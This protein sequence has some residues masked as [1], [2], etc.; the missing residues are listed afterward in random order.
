MLW[1]RCRRRLRVV[2]II[3][4]MSANDLPGVSLLGF[5]AKLLRRG[6]ATFAERAFLCVF[7]SVQIT[8]ASLQGCL[9]STRVIFLQELPKIQETLRNLRTMGSMG[10]YT[11]V[12]GAL[13]AFPVQLYRRAQREGNF[14]SAIFETSEDHDRRIPT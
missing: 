14:L 9:W 4:A 2:S 6:G 7:C 1:R 13:Q 11:L 10:L 12:V 8:R 5:E 3:D